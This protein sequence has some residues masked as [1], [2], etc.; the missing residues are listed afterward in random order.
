LWYDLS[1]TFTFLQTRF[2]NHET[3]LLV[4][5][6]AQFLYFNLIKKDVTYAA[7]VP[8]HTP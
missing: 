8:C 3:L 2:V 5:L 7:N 6:R 1:N 4:Y